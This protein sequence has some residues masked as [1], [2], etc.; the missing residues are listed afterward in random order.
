[1]L[2]VKI[3]AFPVKCE[4][5][6]Q[7]PS[8]SA[9]GVSAGMWK[10]PRGLPEKAAGRCFCGLFYSSGAM[11]RIHAPESFRIGGSFRK[12]SR[13]ARTH[14]CR[15]SRKSRSMSRISGVS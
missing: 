15:V 3:W 7:L 11:T 6:E 1:M 10:T 14:F 4:N 5:H 12:S 9:G 13:L 8:S 2:I